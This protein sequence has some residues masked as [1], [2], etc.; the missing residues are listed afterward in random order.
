ML[1][2]LSEPFTTSVSTECTEG[3]CG[4]DLSDSWGPRFSPRLL[5]D[6][7]GFPTRRLE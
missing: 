6:R 4:N 2:S 3:R 7:P 1:V 5:R